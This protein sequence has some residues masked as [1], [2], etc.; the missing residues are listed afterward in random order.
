[1]EEIIKNLLVSLT[2]TT[3][4]KVCKWSEGTEEGEYYTQIAER[5]ILYSQHVEKNS[6]ELTLLN[7]AGAKIFGIGLTP[8]DKGLYPLA[9][10]LYT[11]ILSSNDG[12]AETIKDII[13]KLDSEK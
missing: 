6:Y 9:E 1:M 10:K 5:A 2:V 13:S 12:I 4:K 11:T 7:D 8:E 3:E